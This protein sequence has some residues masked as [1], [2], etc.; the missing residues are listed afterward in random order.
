LEFKKVILYKFG[1]ECN[2]NVWN[3]KGKDTDQR[4]KVEYFFNKLYVA[5][6]RATEHLF[7]VDSEKG[8]RQLWDY[9]SNEGLLQAMLRFARSQERWENSVQ[10]IST[11]TPRTIQQLR[12][13]DPGAIAQE[14]ETKGLNAHNPDLLRR[15]KQFY[16]DLGDTLKIDFCEAWALKF[17]EQ[18]LN[19]G[20]R[21]IQLGRAQEAWEC[22]WQGMCWQELVA[23]YDRHSEG[24]SVERSLAIFMVAQLDDQK[25]IE[26]FTSLVR[27]EWLAVNSHSEQ[28]L[29]NHKQWKKA[30]EKYANSIEILLTVPDL[31]SN[32]WQ[33]FGEVLEALEIAGYTESQLAGQCFYR[34][35]NYEQVV[36]YGEASSA[37]QKPEYNR[38]KAMLL[39]IP[40]SLE[41]LAQAGDHDSITLLWEQAG[42]PRD[43]AWLQYVA[44]ALEAKQQ[45]QQAFVVYIWL[46][47]FVKVKECFEIASQGTPQIKLLTVLL[48][49]F[50]RN[51]YWSNAI[52]TLENYLPVVI[53]SERQKVALKCEFVYEIACS[54]IIPEGLLKED[55][56]RCKKFIKEQ[57]LSTSDWNQHLLMQQVGVALEKIG[58]FV[59]ALEFYEQF[60]SYPDLQISHFARERWIATKKKQEEYAANQGQLDKASKTQAEL[61]KKARNWSIDYQS[62]PIEPP[63]P[64]RER[65]TEQILDPRATLTGFST[66]PTIPK[67]VIKGLPVGTKV[68]QLEGGVVRFGV[69][70]L[71]VKVMRQSKQ[72]LIM[73]ALNRR[74]VRVDGAQSKVTIGEA[75]VESVGGDRLVFTL[76]TSGYS[77]T[78]IK[79]GEKPQLEL[80]VQGLSS[81][82]SLEL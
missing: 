77:G 32:Q 22:Y 8:D 46:D 52:E 60:I 5:A 35:E 81:K 42:R 24:D 75:T 33:Q 34:A 76:S 73:D 29:K 31:K 26:N 14:F 23:W 58:S 37:I 59:E 64:P 9:A 38:A 2:Q 63:S 21:F 72:V 6:S 13:D 7:V 56:K 51:K 79:A 54:E 11:G 44:P 49:Y 55:R 40:E 45:H 68:E 41:Y 71:V 16:S 28:Q 67:L 25:A 19:A 66:L 82:I 36:R 69:R 62:V 70:H 27:S 80:N 50:Y 53:G 78:L 20:N 48:Q 12:E 15:A 61:L 65:P 30:I 3:I 4:V 39:G 74:E 10:T 18:F 47:E 17:E 57:V 1:E 43:R